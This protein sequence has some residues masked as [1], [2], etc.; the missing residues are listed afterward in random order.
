M[1]LITTS[2]PAV[3][4]VAPWALAS[5]TIKQTEKPAL[6]MIWLKTP[7]YGLPT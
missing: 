4:C 7:G 2:V 3:E 5:L 1:P 6:L